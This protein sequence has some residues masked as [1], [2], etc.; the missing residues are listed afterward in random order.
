MH[1]YVW[2]HKVS[3]NY[4]IARWI[5]ISIFTKLDRDKVLISLH[6]KLLGQIRL[7][8]DPGQGHNRSMTGPSPKDLFLVELEGYSNILMRQSV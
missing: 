6:I 3:F 7:G 1:V 5:S 8:A 2:I 4:R